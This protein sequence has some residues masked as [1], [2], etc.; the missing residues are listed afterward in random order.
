MTNAPQDAQTVIDGIRQALDTVRRI[1]PEMAT[2]AIVGTLQ[3]MVIKMGELYATNIATLAELTVRME[4]L[5]KELQDV[6]RNSRRANQSG[7]PEKSG[8]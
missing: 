8:S 6:R 4:Q 2:P 3:S 5:E 1:H 7:D